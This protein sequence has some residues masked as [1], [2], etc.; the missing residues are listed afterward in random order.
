MEIHYWD[1]FPETLLWEQS[2]LLVPSAAP[3]DP[4]SGSHW[5]HESPEVSSQYKGKPISVGGR[6]PWRKTLPQ[7]IPRTN[8]SENFSDLP[9]HRRHFLTP[10]LS[11]AS[12]STSAKAA[13]RSEDP[14]TSALFL[15]YFSS[16]IKSQESSQ[17]LKIIFLRMSLCISESDKSE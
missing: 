6:I 8:L 15:V 17:Q 10:S 12:P 1:L 16:L 3:L 7:G 4:L 11:L 2:W 13:L 9:S 5:G 14:P